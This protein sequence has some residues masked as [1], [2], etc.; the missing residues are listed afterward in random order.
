MKTRY[1][2]KNGEIIV[3]KTQLYISFSLADKSNKIIF[4]LKCPDYQLTISLGK[5]DIT[6]I[7][8]NKQI[9]YYTINNK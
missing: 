8:Q 2:E 5:Y 9:N 1:E 6:L 4:P 7:V 3:N